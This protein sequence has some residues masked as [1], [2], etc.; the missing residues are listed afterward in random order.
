MSNL[1]DRVTAIMPPPATIEDHGWNVYEEY[2]DVRPS[3]YSWLIETYGAGGIE[4]YITVLDPG[5]DRTFAGSVR[6]ETETARAVWRTWDRPAIAEDVLLEPIAW[7]VSASSDLLCWNPSKVEP[8]EWTVLVWSRSSTSWHELPFGILEF[9]IAI[10][11]DSL[12]PW[13]LSDVGIK[14]KRNPTWLI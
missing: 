10:V 12:H 8:D 13:L 1:R 5:G 11:D 14:G 3:D 7:G 4:D 6:Q 2:S 9:L